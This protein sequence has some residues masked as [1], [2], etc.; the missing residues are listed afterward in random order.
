M[1]AGQQSGE[2]GD[3]RISKQPKPRK[4]REKKSKFSRDEG[5]WQ[6]R[7]VGKLLNKINT[8]ILVAAPGY[9]PGKGQVTTGG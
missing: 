6:W 9:Q 3:D 5:I 1:G 2:E 7:D 4:E 8:R